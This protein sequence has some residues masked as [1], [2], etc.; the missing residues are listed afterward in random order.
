MRLISGALV[1]LVL[2]C[3]ISAL[4]RPTRV[5]GGEKP[6]TVQRQGKSAAVTLAPAVRA[7]VRLYFP[8][9]GLPALSEFDPDALESGGKGPR[10]PFA[11][12][13]DF[14]GNGLP[15]IAL[16]LRNRSRHW[17]L[18]A[19]HQ[20]RGGTFRPYRL[21]RWVEQNPRAV[22]VIRM[23]PAGYAGFPFTTTGR[24]FHGFVIPHPGI[25]E[26]IPAEAGTLYYFRGGK[27]RHVSFNW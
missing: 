15:D 20:T 22:M 23:L 8:G 18:V 12:T 26:E 14:D 17:L 24:Q 9:F 13:A 3:C 27:Y 19:L 2:G 10:V 21:D 7:A 25:I 16:L 5:V 4:G 6:M 1:A 11:T